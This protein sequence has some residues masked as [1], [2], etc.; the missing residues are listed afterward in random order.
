[1][2]LQTDINWITKELT[3]RNDPKLI[4]LLMNLIKALGNDDSDWWDNI[5]E[6]ERIE[7]NLGLSQ[8]KSGDVESHE[9]VLNKLSKWL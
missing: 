9:S 8:L 5:S 6:E 2:D 7:I 4:K 3:E 1:M